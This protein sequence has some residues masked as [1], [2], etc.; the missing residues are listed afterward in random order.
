MRNL[1]AVA[2]PLLVLASFVGP[3]GGAAK[4]TFEERARGSWL[5]PDA[6]NRLLSRLV[7]AKDDGGWRLE[8]WAVRGLKEEP[9]SKAALHLLRSGA[10]GQGP[11]VRGLAVWKEGAGDGEATFYT[12]LRFQG[13]DLIVDLAKV[14]HRPRYAS[15]FAS[16]TLKK[17]AP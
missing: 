8:V 6:P 13:N 5:A 2:Y 15:W 9:V 3:P 14:Y 10:G 16:Y 1:Q 11:V 12:T 7:V 4:P 17:A